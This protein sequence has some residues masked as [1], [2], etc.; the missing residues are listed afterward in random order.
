MLFFHTHTCPDGVGGPVIHVSFHS[1]D[2]SGPVGASL[3]LCVSVCLSV[4]IDEN[5]CCPSVRSVSSSS[6]SCSDP[7]KRVDSDIRGWDEIT[8][9]VNLSIEQLSG[10]SERSQSGFVCL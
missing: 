7:G 2:Y 8:D 6:L 3:S 1:W 4:F 9:G 10:E 5:L